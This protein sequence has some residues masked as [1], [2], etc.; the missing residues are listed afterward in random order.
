[1]IPSEEEEAWHYVAV[2]KLSALLQG[3]TSKRKGD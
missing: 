2:R 3:I 1:M